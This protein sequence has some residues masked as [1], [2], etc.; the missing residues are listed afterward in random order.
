MSRYDGLIIP[1]S[2]SEYINKT[3]AATLSQALQLPSVM[4]S[5]PTE[6]SNRPV[7]S[8]GIYTALAGKQPTLTF[9]TIPTE[10]SNNPVESGGVYNTLAN[11]APTFNTVTDYA[12]GDYVTYNNMLYRCI[13]AH[14][15]GI[16]VA[17]HFTQVTVGREL[18]DKAYIKPAT[19]INTDTLGLT[20]QN[21]YTFIEYYQA[22]VSHG[23]DVGQYILDV[24]PN[25]KTRVYVKGDFGKK[26]TVSINACTLEIN[27][28]ATSATSPYQILATALILGTSGSTAMLAASTGSGKDDY[29][30]CVN[31]LSL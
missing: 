28:L 17:G 31:V 5:T 22:L 4:D 2:Y 11:F 6:N 13:T 21:T 18:K 10:G 16:W 1:R 3:D 14:T 9:D 12:V 7:R 27:I 23:F 24:Q 25:D 30:S 8:G 20:A 26:D 19:I 29:R 15:A